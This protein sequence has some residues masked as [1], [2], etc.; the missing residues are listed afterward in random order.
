MNYTEHFN[1]TETDQTCAIPGK[2]QV[3]N[4]AGG[5]VFAMD[6]WG[7]LD[8]FLILG[9]E[10]GTYYV[11]ENKLTVDNAEHV[12]GLIKKDGKRVARRANEI[13]TS[14]RA[15]KNDPAIFVLAL[16]CTFGDDESKSV[17][18]SLISSIC[19]TGTHLFTFCNN[20]KALRGWSRGLRTGVAQFYLGKDPEA[21]AYQIIKYRQRGGWTHKDVLRLS[22]PKSDSRDVDSFDRAKIMSYAVGKGN[23]SHPLISA[24]ET[25]QSNEL[26]SEELCGIVK[27]NK[28]PW[29][30]IPTQYLNRVDVWETMLPT[31]PLT[32][33]VRNLGK[34]TSLG[35][36]NSNLSDDTRQATS[37]LDNQDTIKRSKIHPMSILMALRTYENGCGLK[38]SLSWSPNASIISSLEKAFYKAFVNVEPTNKRFYIGLDV[39]GS[40]TSPIMNTSMSCRE[41]AAALSMVLIDKE[42]LCEV[43][44]FTRSL[45]DLG[46]RK[47]MTLK[48]VM[49][50][51][52]ASNFG[53]T[54]CA[55][56]MLDA[57]ERG[58][59]IDV[60]VVITDN[61]TYAGGIHP[62][63]ALN[64]YRKQMGIDA[65]LIVIGMTSTGFTIADPGDP[66][67]LDIVGFDAAIPEL[68]SNFIK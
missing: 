67:M 18:Y 59:K 3:E 22:H 27:A 54:D 61:E 62:S 21:L 40:M 2:K 25:I 20:I 68:I 7:R 58:L 56:P 45:V 42:P 11:K 32:A 35:M 55:Q 47:G 37:I 17:S 12:V 30:A 46:L 9:T 52:Y 10:G 16:C 48:E 23:C 28:L 44:G 53:R 1:T 38:G 64:K 33:L 43:R 6:D 60:F 13:S 8:R 24:F 31:M 15:P 5:F 50:R 36:F 41:A 4:N 65:K 34:M 63:Q 57:L 29:E 19:R 66:G 39:S 51:T 14:G 49:D 26:P